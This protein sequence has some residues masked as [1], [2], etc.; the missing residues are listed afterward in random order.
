MLLL[1]ELRFTQKVGSTVILGLG[2]VTIIREKIPLKSFIKD[3]G[4]KKVF[5]IRVEMIV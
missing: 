2:D 5:D 3:Y 4:A 1:F